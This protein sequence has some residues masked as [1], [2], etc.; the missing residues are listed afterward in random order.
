[1]VENLE[2][3]LEGL[4][5]SEELECKLATGADGQGK[6]PRDFWPTYSAFANTRGGVIVLGAKEERS[7]FRVEGIPQPSKVLTELFDLAGNP[8]KVSCNLLSE[9]SVSTGDYR[10]KNLVLVRIPAASRKQKPV[11]LNGNPLKGN[12]Y[13]RLFDGDHKCDDATVQRMLAEKQ[14]EDR[15]RRIL[16]DFGQGD[17]D[18]PS[19]RAYRRMFRDVKP[20]HTW[21]D[22]SDWELLGKLQGWRKDR[23]NGEQG[24]TLAGLAMFGRWE[25]IQEGLPGFWVDYQERPEARTD[26][27]W[28]DRV[29]PDGTWPANLFSFYRRIYPK[30]ISDLKVPFRIK[31][32]QRRD[33]TP[34]H[35]AVREGLVNC[36]VHADLQGRGSILVVKRPDLLGFRN[37]GGMRVPVHQAIEG[38]FSDCRNGIMHQMFLMVGLVERAGSGVPRIYS[39]WTSGH[40]RPP[41]LYENIELEQTLLELRM[42]DLL[43]EEVIHMLRR[44][45]S[46]SFDELQALEKLILATAAVESIVSHARVSMM[47]REHAHDISLAFQRLIR[48]GL[49]ESNGRGKGTV[50]HLPGDFLPSPDDVFG[51]V[52]PIETAK[53]LGP[54]A[55]ARSLSS[56]VPSSRFNVPSSSPNVP[57]SSPNIPSSSPNV[58]SSSPNVPSSDLNIERLGQ[59]G[60]TRQSSDS[61]VEAV[62]NQANSQIEKVKGGAE[63]RDLHGRFL[64]PHLQYPLIDDLTKLTPHFLLEL[65]HAAFIPTSSKRLSQVEMDAAIISVCEGHYVTRNVLAQILN[66]SADQLGKRFLFRLVRE[67]K[68]LPAFPKTP[69]HERQAYTKAPE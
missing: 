45:F 46:D 35:E 38:G 32:G 51:P 14:E 52:T 18:W 61:T 5:E 66:R 11:F 50:Y 36:I 17:I 40:W 26:D 37:P 28:V 30:L 57:S 47:A 31:D 24:L 39:G 65:Q 56:K 23:E 53:V 10:G 49:L 67:R 25:S 6:L 22:L 21:L 13:R 16:T 42:L 9:S 12:T 41:V 48:V 58:P 33:F 19:F 4:R 63:V 60:E 55:N 43:P 69:T 64:S 34:I 8:E 15:D 44:R 54:R 1:M 62:A 3:L 7:G 27:R 20:G 59:P 2:D 29:Y 68:L